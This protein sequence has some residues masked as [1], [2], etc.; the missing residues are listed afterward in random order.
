MSEILH[1]LAWVAFVIASGLL[2]PRVSLTVRY[3]R[4]PGL[5]YTWRRAWRAAGRGR[6]YS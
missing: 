2:W 6:A 1:T 3:K 5:R 4:D